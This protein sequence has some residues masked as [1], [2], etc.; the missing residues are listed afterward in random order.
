MNWTT[1]QQT[2]EIGSGLHDE[3][4]ARDEVRDEVRDE[5]RDERCQF[6]TDT[7]LKVV[8]SRGK[9]YLSSES[10]P[11]CQF[12]TVAKTHRRTVG[13]RKVRQR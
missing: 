1:G 10:V 4:E 5:A 9:N 12:G 13:I 8:E 6:G 2:G 3:D 7:M 11:R